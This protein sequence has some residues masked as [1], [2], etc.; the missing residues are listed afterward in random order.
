[1]LNANRDRVADPAVLNLQLKTWKMR[2]GSKEE[3]RNMPK[4]D[5]SV[6]REGR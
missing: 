2:S 5:E 6:V 4:G 1:M 3:G